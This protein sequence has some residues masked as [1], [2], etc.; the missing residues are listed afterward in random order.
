MAYRRWVF[1]FLSAAGAEATEA[2][3]H[4]AG[5][6]AR[7]LWKALRDGTRMPIVG[8]GTWKSKSGEVQAAVVHAICEA[9]YRHIDAAQIYGNQEEVGRGIRRAIDGCGVKRGDLWVTSKI[10]MTDYRPEDLPGATDRILRELGLDYVDQLL[11]HW[12]VPLEK[13]PPGCPPSCPERLASTDNVMR[14]R[15]SD[16]N[17]VLSGLPVTEAWGALVGQKRAGKVRSVGVSNFQ[18]SEIDELISARLEAPAVNQVEL[19]VFW[20]QPELRRAMADRGVALVAY[21]PLGNPALY[22]R[23][24]DGL[25]SAM[26]AEAAAKSGLTPAQV[27][28]NFLIT[29]DAVVVPKSVTPSRISSNIDFRL[30][31][32]AEDVA[33]LEREAPQA[34]LANPGLRHGGQPVFDDSSAEAGQTA[35]KA[36]L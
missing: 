36:E 20:H 19:H 13:P 4:S 33:R 15:G 1:L 12:P 17:Y 11:L 5:P 16:G 18:P 3:P 9:G 25:S 8:L 23:K 2:S 35:R 6:S 24:L 32:T 7:G 14:P 27:M 34:R 30:N 10:W 29:L 21:S 28:L 31:L 22:A 26:I